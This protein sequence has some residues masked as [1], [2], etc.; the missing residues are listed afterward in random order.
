MKDGTHL[1]LNRLECKRLLQEDRQLLSY[2]QTAEWG[3]RT[4]QGTFGHLRIPLQ[5][6]YHEIQGDLLETCARLFN[7]RA[8]DVGINQIQSVYMPNWREDEPEELWMTFESTL[9]STQRKNDQVGHFHM[10]VVE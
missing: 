7:L 4:I 2:R 8:R 9:F 1:P 6:A 3:M 5:I 10:I